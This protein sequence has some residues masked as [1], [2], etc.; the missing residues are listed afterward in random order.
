MITSMNTQGGLT[1]ANL[2]SSISANSSP[3]SNPSFTSAAQSNSTG[4]STFDAGDPMATIKSVLARARTEPARSLAG[5]PVTGITDFAYAF[6]RD[7][8]FLPIHAPT[9]GEEVDDTQTTYPWTG[10]GQDDVIIRAGVSPTRASDATPDSTPSAP[11]RQTS[12]FDPALAMSEATGAMGFSIESLDQPTSAP[13][14]FTVEQGDLNEQVELNLGVE[15]DGVGVA[16]HV[17]GL[18]EAQAR[19]IDA[20]FVR[21]AASLSAPARKTLRISL[22]FVYYGIPAPGFVFSASADCY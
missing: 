10:L 20:E 4:G 2:L 16:F 1:A 5:L 21:A 13:D 3:S 22:S 9:P 6:Q 17:F 18:D 15:R 14:A 11:T 12:T 19:Q 7:D 8:N